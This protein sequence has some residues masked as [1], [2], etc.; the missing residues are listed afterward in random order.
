[1][2][3]AMF[4]AG[5][6]FLRRPSFWLLAWTYRDVLALWGR[7]LAAEARRPGRFDGERIGTLVKGLWETTKQSRFAVQVPLHDIRVADEVVD[8]T[9]EHMVVGFDSLT[10]TAREPLGG[11]RA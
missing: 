10:D 7:S 4:T 9:D 8:V 11:V 6:K 1:M 3:R 5:R 2:I